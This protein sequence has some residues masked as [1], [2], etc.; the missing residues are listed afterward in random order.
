M[1]PS[2]ANGSSLARPASVAQALEQTVIP[3]VTRTRAKLGPTT[4]STADILQALHAAVALL[5]ELHHDGDAHLPGR[6]RQL[7]DENE[8]LRSENAEIRGE[9]ETATKALGREAAKAR[10]LTREV[11]EARSFADRRCKAMYRQYKNEEEIGESLY[12]MTEEME[13]RILY[14]ERQLGV[15]EDERWEHN[16]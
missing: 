11:G 13:E 7:E 1:P 12:M 2:G 6:L 14:L 4:R 5:K 3:A 16:K 8:K 15:D 10:R 9:L